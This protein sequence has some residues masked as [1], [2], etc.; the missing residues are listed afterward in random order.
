MAYGETTKTWT[1]LLDGQEHELRLEHHYWTGDKRFYLDDRLIHHIPGGLRASA[2]FA[3]DVPFTLGA[4][5]GRFRYRAIGP[6]TF[7]DLVIDGQTIV[8]D[9]RAGLR[10]PPW[11]VAALV[12]GLFG[13]AWLSMEA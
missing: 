5:Q 8:G 1:V 13:L 11:L 9:E 12:A 2:S 7:Y 4:H 3:D 6:M 10:L